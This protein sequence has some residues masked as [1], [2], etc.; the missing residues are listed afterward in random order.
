M[1]SCSEPQL[2]YLASPIRARKSPLL[3]AHL[4]HGITGK[5]PKHDR[6]P[7]KGA[8]GTRLHGHTHT[9]TASQPPSKPASAIKLE[10]TYRMFFNF[11]SQLFASR[12]NLQDAT[13]V[14]MQ[15]N[16][17]GLLMSSNMGSQPPAGDQQKS[18]KIIANLIQTPSALQP[19][20]SQ[21][22]PAN[23]IMCCCC[24]CRY[25]CCK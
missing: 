3:L 11:R 1:S 9:H 17:Q 24:C 13:A 7:Y 6:D 14:S 23:C 25:S 18:T 2:H 12:I 20:V 15:L 4:L 16:R 8:Q 19:P 22:T 10:C 21:H 5:H